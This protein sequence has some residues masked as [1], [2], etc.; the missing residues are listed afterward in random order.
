MRQRQSRW[1]WADRRLTLSVALIVGLIALGSSALTTLAA[2]TTAGAPIA[3]GHAE[4]IAQG[5]ESLPQN[6]VNWRITSLR[7]SANG[8]PTVSDGHTGFVLAD[9]GTILVTDQSGAR[10]MLAPGEAV[11]TRGGAPQTV[12]SLGKG[13]RASAYV[14]DLVDEGTPYLGKQSDL[15]AVGNPFTEVADMDVSLV[16]DV[17]QPGEA[18]ELEG[19][20][21]PFTVLVTSGTIRVAATEQAVLHSGMVGSFSGDMSLQATGSRPATVVVAVVSG[22][23]DTVQAP[24]PAQPTAAPTT[25]P[26]PTPTVPAPAEQKGSITVL[27]YGCPPGVELA[28]FNDPSQCTS[29]ADAVNLQLSGRALDAPLTAADAN[30]VDGGYVWQ[31]IP[32]SS[33]QIDAIQFANPYES[34]FIPGSAEVGGT[35][36]GNYTVSID[37][38]RPDIGLEV[39]LFQPGTSE[40]PQSHGATGQITVTFY[41]CPPAMDVSN[42]NPAGCDVTTDPLI[43]LTVSGGDLQFPT[44]MQGPNGSGLYYSGDLTLATYTL[45]MSSMPDLYTTYFIPG[46][47]AVGGSPDTGYTVTLDESAPTISLEVYLLAPA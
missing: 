41:A 40:T 11:L 2:Q 3:Q 43:G 39:Y 23:P 15:V 5:V 16:R 36:E 7:P 25:A 35:P 31:N 24:A 18:T 10:T 8:S 44:L 42:L 32:V 33:Y 20:D 1:Q 47:A 4:V 38:S 9:K 19:T 29:A 12:A 21:A 13:Q 14:F 34:Y 46:S 28:N 37:P 22:G 27:I 26:A 30:T 45:N 6:P 17:L